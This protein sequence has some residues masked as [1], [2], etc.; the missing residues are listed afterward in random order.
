MR[1]PLLA[2]GVVCDPNLQCGESTNVTRPVDDAWHGMFQN[3]TVG[4]GGACERY[5]PPLSPWC[6]GDFYLLRQFPEMHTRS[7][8][9]V[10]AES[11]LPH[12]ARYTT[13]SHETAVTGSHPPTCG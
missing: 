9:G 4:V 12:S 10:R 7:P 6:S 11:H 1:L 3:Y 13:R 5:D 2:D 8:A